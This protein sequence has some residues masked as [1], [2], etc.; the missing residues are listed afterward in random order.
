MKQLEF[1]LLLFLS[2]GIM[3]CTLNGQPVKNEA[4][5]GTSEK[6]EVLSCCKKPSRFSAI[7]QS[8]LDSSS[9]LTSTA[10]HAGM[11]WIKGG[12]Y[13]MGSSDQQGRPDEYPQHKVQVNGF[14]MDATEVTNA[15]FRKFVAATGYITTAEK[16]PNWE[17]LKKQLPPG[18]PKPDASLL[19]AASL[20]FMP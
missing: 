15:Q 5:P 1:V 7:Q 13:V 12:E 14:W 4:Q 11:V 17:E 8:K 10:S 6:K 18:T 19:V 9:V 3:S 2:A 20:V 16:A